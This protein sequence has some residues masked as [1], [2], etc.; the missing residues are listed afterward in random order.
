[1]QPEPNKSQARLVTNLGQNSDLIEM[2]LETS[3][4]MFFKQKH[5][6]RMIRSVFPVADSETQLQPEE[7][8]KESVNVIGFKLATKCN[9]LGLDN[10]V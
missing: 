4:L 10:D 6:L 2:S 3:S 9:E 7:E 1:M 8:E 5:T